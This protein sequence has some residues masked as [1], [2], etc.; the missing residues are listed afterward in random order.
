MREVITD[1][2]HWNGFQI[3]HGYP[4]F[5]NTKHVG[6]TITHNNQS[7]WVNERLTVASSI[8]ILLKNQDKGSQRYGRE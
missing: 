8:Y 6:E 7:Q 1:Y 3:V 5:V 2:G 4:Q